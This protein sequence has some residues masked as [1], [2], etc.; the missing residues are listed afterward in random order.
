MLTKVFFKDC[1]TSQNDVSELNLHGLTEMKIPYAN[2]I[3]QN[4]I[5]EALKR[6]CKICN[7][8]YSFKK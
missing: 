3:H 1:Y 4:D 2:H 6:V 8:P 7:E 5:I